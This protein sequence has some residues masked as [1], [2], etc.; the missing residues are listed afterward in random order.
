MNPQQFWKERDA[1]NNSKPT[2]NRVFSGI[3]SGDNT[4]RYSGAHSQYNSDGT[5]K[6]WNGSAWVPMGG[7]VNQDVMLVLAE[8]QRNKNAFAILAEN[9]RVD[10]AIL[11]VVDNIVKIPYKYF[12]Q[13]LAKYLYYII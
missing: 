6:R 5:Q 1:A 10:I 4:Y 12:T 8:I 3:P 11:A 9:K 13:S 7:V 2:T